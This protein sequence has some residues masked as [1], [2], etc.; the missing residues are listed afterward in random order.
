[1]HAAVPADRGGGGRSGQGRRISAAAA[2]Q[3]GGA[4]RQR[5]LRRIGAAAE[6]WEIGCV[7]GC[8]PVISLEMRRRRA[9]CPAVIYQLKV[10]EFT[11]PHTTSFDKFP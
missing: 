8:E 1:M 4:R 2:D 5:L 11:C 6:D 10:A 3:R 9:T 7:L